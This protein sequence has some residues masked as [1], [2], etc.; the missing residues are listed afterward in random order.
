V[1]LLFR[2]SSPR[3]E[4]VDHIEAQVDRGVVRVLLVMGSSSRREARC[5]RAERQNRTRAVRFRL[6]QGVGPR[7][8][9][10][11][12]LPTVAANRRG[13]VSACSG[14]LL[15]LLKTIAP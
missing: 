13:A 3:C 5:L 10:D 12:S 2:G 15:S 9:V 8:I 6:A 14:S 11:G 7:P 1:R 4:L